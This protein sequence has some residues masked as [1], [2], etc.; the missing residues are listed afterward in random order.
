MSFLFLKWRDRLVGAL[1]EL[2]VEKTPHQVG[3]IN[4]SV[5]RKDDSPINQV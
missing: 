4:G 2:E 1:R 5:E 3:Q